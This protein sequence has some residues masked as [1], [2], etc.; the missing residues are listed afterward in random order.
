M[1]N[2]TQ[3]I[4]NHLTATGTPL[5]TLVNTRVWSPSAPVAWRNDS[6]AVIFD[7]ITSTWHPTANDAQVRVM[8]N[9]Y[10]GADTYASADAVYRALYDRLHGV[11]GARVNGGEISYTKLIDGSPGQIEPVTEWK[12]ARA[13]F[14][15]RLA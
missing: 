10:G 1:I 11:I 8:F 5:Y 14:E 2:P 15:M 3:I 13:I 6:A 12:Y 4:W 9:C 7:I